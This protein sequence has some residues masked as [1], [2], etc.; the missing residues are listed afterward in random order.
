LNPEDA[1]FTKMMIEALP[2]PLEKLYISHVKAF[3]YAFV[4]GC[5]VIINTF[6]LYFFATM[7]PLF[8][9]NWISILIAWSWNYTLSVG[10]L[11]YLFGLGE[12]K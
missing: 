12:K 6:L 10:P 7:F 1:K 11:G 5:G 4:A 9:A 3:N 2:K 8:M